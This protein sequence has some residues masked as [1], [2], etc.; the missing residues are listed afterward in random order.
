MTE[1]GC[2]SWFVCLKTNPQSDCLL[3]EGGALQI[4]ISRMCLRLLCS[5]KVSDLK[6][7]LHEV[8]SL[9][10][11]SRER[12][13]CCV[14]CC[15]S[16]RSLIMYPSLIWLLLKWYTWKYQNLSSTWNFAEYPDGVKNN[17]KGL[18]QWLKVKRC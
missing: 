15:H 7:P 17:R 11:A 6:C 18:V 1:L 2:Y 13:E 4:L 8:T 14:R 3:G 10:F 12:L 5:G 9:S 16:F